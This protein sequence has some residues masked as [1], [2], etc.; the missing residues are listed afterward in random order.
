MVARGLGRAAGVCGG[1]GGA[2]GGVF[3]VAG[4]SVGAPFFASRS[5]QI[6]PG[7]GG[8]G[9]AQHP[10]HHF[11]RGDTS[12]VGDPPHEPQGWYSVFDVDTST[13]AVIRDYAAALQAQPAIGE[14]G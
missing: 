13:Q 5:G 9:R 11:V 3:T 7:W 12:F 1:V 8:E 2:A 4:A 6:S 10:D 14:R